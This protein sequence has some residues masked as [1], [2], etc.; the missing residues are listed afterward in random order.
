MLFRSDWLRTNI[1]AT[2]DLFAAAG[3][4][5]GLVQFQGGRR[6]FRNVPV[7]T[8]EKFL[9]SYKFHEGAVSMTSRLLTSYIRNEIPS[10]ALTSWNIAIIEGDADLPII[11]LGL[12]D[13]IHTITRSKMGYS[14]P[15][16]ANLKSIASTR[17]RIADVSYTSEEISAR[18]K[19]LATTPDGIGFA[20]HDAAYRKL[21][22]E[23]NHGTGLL[24]IYPID[25]TST[26]RNWD[27]N[28]AT[29]NLAKNA[30]FPLNAVDHMVGITIFFPDAT[31]QNSSV[32]YKSA[33]LSGLIIE[34]PADE[35]AEI[36]A[37][38]AA[39]EEIGRAHV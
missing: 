5:P 25:S 4:E 32:A 28:S 11:D 16:Q 19:D 31:V 36:N 37:I 20:R 3:G 35:A 12:A 30:R 39:G 29:Q 18:L 9:K 38:D 7:R 10:G 33:D 6:G 14:Q 1:D 34:D 24:C 27:E 8:V 2:R 23:D 17:D 26:P 13:P 22:A 15:G 21:R